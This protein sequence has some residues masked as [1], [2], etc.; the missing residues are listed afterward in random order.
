[1]FVI[2]TPNYGNV[3]L[4]EQLHIYLIN[5]YFGVYQ[6]SL[7]TYSHQRVFTVDMK[8]IFVPIPSLQFYFFVSW[9]TVTFEQPIT[10]LLSVC[11]YYLAMFIKWHLSRV[12]AEQC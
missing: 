12:A 11:I 5:L 9:N 10:I 2:S 7:C 8:S 1:M 3:I 4:L 6:R